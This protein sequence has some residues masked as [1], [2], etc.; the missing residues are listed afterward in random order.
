[1]SRV[2]L[3]TLT[4]RSVRN[5]GD[6][7]PAVK[8]KVLLLLKKAYDKG[9][10]VQISSGYRSNA[11]QNALYAKGRTAP[12]NV[13][14]N[15]RAGQSVH[16]YGLAVDYF[17][18]SND[19]NDSIWTVNDDWKTVARLGKEMGF[20]WGGDW[21][22]FPDFPHLDLSGG[23]GWRDLKAGKRKHSIL[24]EGNPQNGHSGMT[25]YKIQQMLKDKGYDITVDGFYGDGTEKVVK[26][27]QKK[28][29]LTVDGIVGN[30]TMDALKKKEVH[31][32]STKKEE[33]P[34]SN[35][36]S[37]WA[38]E[39]WNEAVKNGYYDGSRPKENISR[40]ESAIV[41]NRLRHNFN[42]LIKQNEEAIEA[43]KKE[44]KELKEKQK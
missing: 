10:N 21:R 7:H 35:G 25:T 4:D 32:A 16:N 40:E 15:A 27:F 9:I 14:T 19:G 8:D 23:Y 2:S 20:T 11:R 12:G 3:E 33:K 17:L 6:V 37:D 42:E 5:M 1:M 41:T 44:V 31:A 24:N 36:P 26:D 28:N 38:K 43:L 22:S 34:M 18:V 30:N 29:K 13:V 39:N